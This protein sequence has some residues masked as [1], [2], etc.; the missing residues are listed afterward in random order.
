V[1][2]AF[3]GKKDKM[4]VNHIN[5]NKF[6]NRVV[7]LENISSRENIIHALKTGLKKPSSRKINQYNM[8]GIFIKSFNSIREAE[9]IT[10]ASEKHISAV[11]K[12]KRK[13]TG[14]FIWKYDVPDE[15]HK[16]DITDTKNVKKI[17]NFDNY[18]ITRD[19]KVYSKIQNK[20]LKT[21]FDPDGYE[22]VSLRMQGIKNLREDTSIHRLIAKY[23]IPNPNNYPMVNH[24]DA[25]K[26]NNN[27]D[28]LEWCSYSHNMKHHVK[29][30]KAKC[31]ANGTKP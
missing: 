19:G 15:E 29:L 31:E 8:G 30:Q 6:D 13:S 25:N 26:S 28:N 24:I 2:T 17:D 14:G 3:I 7:N 18:Y 5:G 21:K 23:F 1:A 16:I 12:N 22:L 4:I 10:G 11:C 9:K 20:I 27:I